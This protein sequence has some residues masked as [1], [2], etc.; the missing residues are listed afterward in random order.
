MARPKK[1]TFADLDLEE[2]DKIASLR[3]DDLVAYVAKVALDQQA[4]MKAKE[5]DQ[6]LAEKKEAA[7]DAGAQYRDGTKGNKLRIAFAKR[8]MDDRTGD[9][10]TTIKN[11]VRERLNAPNEDREDLN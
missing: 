3:G 9:F 10:V 1:D 2:Q 11:A 7:K 6:D 4:L 8:V 5:E